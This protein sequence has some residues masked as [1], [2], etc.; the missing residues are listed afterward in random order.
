[1]KNKSYDAAFQA[2]KTASE[3]LRDARI[4]ATGAYDR[5]E[6]ARTVHEAAVK[7]YDAV[8]KTYEATRK[9][10]DIANKA[11]KEQ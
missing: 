4:A 11:R 3:A 1:M 7:L 9:A 8:Y 10:R 2:H 5:V 6:I